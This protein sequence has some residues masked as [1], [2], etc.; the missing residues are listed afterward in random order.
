MFQAIPETSQGPTP[1]DHT[2]EFFSKEMFQSQHTK[3]EQ[4]FTRTDRETKHGDHSRQ[5]E[6]P[7]HNRERDHD[8]DEEYEEVEILLEHIAKCRK[9]KNF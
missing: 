8:T 2:M 9:D 5:C 7:K 3:I 1:L 6:I 4:P